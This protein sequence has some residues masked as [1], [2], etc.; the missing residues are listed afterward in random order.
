[1]DR[2]QCWANWSQVVTGLIA[3]LSVAWYF[4]RTFYHRFR[5]VRYLR[6]AKATDALIGRQGKRTP[7]HL[8]AELGVSENQLFAAYAFAK[9]RIGYYVRPDAED[10]AKGILLGYKE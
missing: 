1:M 7:I 6:K 2:L 8:M 4:G 9:C 10:Y 3:I 5:L